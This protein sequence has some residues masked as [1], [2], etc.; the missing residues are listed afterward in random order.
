MSGLERYIPKILGGASPSIRNVTGDPTHLNHVEA[1]SSSMAGEHPLF[2]S[3]DLLISLR[4]INIVA[5][6]DTKSL[7][8]KWYSESPFIRQHNPKFVGE[9]W[10]SIFDNNRDFTERGEMLGG[11]RILYLNLSENVSKVFFFPKKSQKEYIRM[12]KGS[13][14]YWRMGTC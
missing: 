5:V 10:I 9:G 12:C 11:N 2:E 3:G 6:L 14:M 7:N 8:V 4:N 13:S 1:L